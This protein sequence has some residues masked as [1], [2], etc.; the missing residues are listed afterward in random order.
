MPAAVPHTST[1]ALT[2]ATFPYLW[3]SPS[4]ASNTP[5]PKS[6]GLRFGVN[7]Y[8]GFITYHAV[9][10]SQNRQYRELS[11]LLGVAA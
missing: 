11:T 5:L 9:A 7:T 6:P 4:K 8:G 3:S 10:D 2:N 1:L